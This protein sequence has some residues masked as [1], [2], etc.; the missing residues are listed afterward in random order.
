MRKFSKDFNI[1]VIAS[2]KRTVHSPKV[3]SFTSFI[4]DANQDELYTEKPYE[5]IDVID[6]IGSGDAYIAETLYGLLKNNWDAKK[7]LQYGNA[8][9]VL[10]N[11][12]PGDILSSSL[13]EINSVIDAHNGNG[14]SSEMNR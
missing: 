1:S 7:A 5:N 4:Y 9:S 2:T 14:S 6:R 10:K 12:I 3:H 8:F 11:T 13:T